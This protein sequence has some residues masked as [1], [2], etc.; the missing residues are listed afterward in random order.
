MAEQDLPSLAA[1]LEKL[2]SLRESGVL[3]DEEFQ[4]AKALRC[5]PQIDP[6]GVLRADDLGYS[7]QR[8]ER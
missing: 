1:E 6:P 7:L 8:K 3:T 5:A 4:K 2:A